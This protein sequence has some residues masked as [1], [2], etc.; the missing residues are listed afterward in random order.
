MKIREATNAD[1]KAVKDLVFGV[2]ASYGLK[3]DPSNTDRDLDDLEAHYHQNGGYFA[4]LE[5]D[6]VVIGSYGIY[7]FSAG[8]CELRK[9]YLRPE[10]RGRGLG[11][12]LLEHALKRAEDLGF[13]VVCL[14]TASVLKEAIALYLKYGFVPYR[15]EHL[16]SRCDQAYRKVLKRANPR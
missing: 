15:A 1:A 14:E 11:K 12:L 7:R 5:A 3:P 13:E 16:A 2:L 6:G 8:E 9:M 4:V 10:F